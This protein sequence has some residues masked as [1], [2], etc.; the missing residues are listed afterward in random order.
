MSEKNP[1]PVQDKVVLPGT[2]E[3]SG[4]VKGFFLS[5]WKLLSNNW[6]MKLVC[7]VLA[8]LL[9]GF[10]YSQDDT[11]TREKEF[12]NVP[13][14]LPKGYVNSLTDGAPVILGWDENRSVTVHVDVPQRYYEELDEGSFSV[15]PDLS[16][17]SAPE[18]NQ[19]ERVKVKLICDIDTMKYGNYRVDEDEI[20][21][22]VDKYVIRPDV[23]VNINRLGELPEGIWQVTAGA[24]D[25]ITLSGPRSLVD[26]VYRID[27]DASVDTLRRG[28][29]KQTVRGS[30]V[31]L[32]DAEGKDITGEMTDP[33]F[34]KPDFIN[35]SVLIDRVKV[36]ENVPVQLPEA[37]VNSLKNKGWVITGWDDTRTATVRV[38]VPREMYGKLTADAVVLRPD[39]G[40]IPKLSGET[41]GEVTV[42]LVCDVD[43]SFGVSSCSVDDG[44][45]RI[46]VEQYGDLRDLAVNAAP[47]GEAPNGYRVASTKVE[48][49]VTVSGPKSLIDRVY[50]IDA[51]V[52]LGT[53]RGET[54]E[55]TVRSSE[56]RLYDELGDP[57]DAEGLTLTVNS[58]AASFVNVTV[59]LE[60]IPAGGEAN[61]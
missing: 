44:E 51:G 14:R 27:A 6:V 18:G 58:R 59:V 53:L 15:Y 21:L 17:L 39:T 5:L 3:Q 23:E 4:R 34:H 49:R 25:A 7:L 12:L 32:Y 41:G 36:L 10:I 20:T 8:V 47:N 57:I 40:S 28:T 42:A 2:K 52:N 37:N 11:L 60:K 30:N 29:D 43:K 33:T 24:A 56:L 61:E 48:S 22:T 46:S 1:G 45:M 19:P 35:V 38:N 55:Q 9:W 26:R 50:R 31:R 13:V 54:G 16:G